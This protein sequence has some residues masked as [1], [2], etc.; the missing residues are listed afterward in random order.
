MKKT[1]SLVCFF[2]LC[3][4]IHSQAQVVEWIHSYET[5]TSSAHAIASDNQANLYFA[6]YIRANGN[7][8][9]GLTLTYS[10]GYE[11]GLVCKADSQGHLQWIKVLGAYSSEKAKY[12]FQKD[13]KVFVG[14]DVTNYGGNSSLQIDNLS[15][16]IP[17]GPI[18]SGYVVQLDTAGIFQWVAFLPGM[19]SS[20]KTDDSGNTYATCNFNDAFIYKISPTGTVVYGFPYSTSSYNCAIAFDPHGNAYGAVNFTDTIEFMGTTYQGH[21]LSDILLFKVSSSGSLLHSGIIGGIGV[22]YV[23]GMMTDHSGNI[24]MTGAWSDTV[25]FSG[26][27]INGIGSRYFILKADTADNLIDYND[28]DFLYPDNNASSWAGSIVEN[29][30]HEI[31]TAINFTDTII[32]GADTLSSHNFGGYDGAGMIAKWDSTLQL[33]WYRRLAQSTNIYNTG[34]ASV[35]LSKAVADKIY[36]CGQMNEHTII[37]GNNYDTNGYYVAFTGLLRDTTFDFTSHLPDDEIQNLGFNIYPSPAS[38]KVYFS[39]RSTEDIKTAQIE[40]HNLYGELIFYKKLSEANGEIDISNLP[41][42][43]YYF[44]FIADNFT[45]TKSVVKIE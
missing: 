28:Q 20:M 37:E 26:T 19:I 38:G 10:Y 18:Y 42:G 32:H 39:L 16:P 17:P 31:L 15:F 25:Y 35:F 1:F 30:N 40:L 45:Q 9:D 8:F 2:C 4:F 14:G 13:D 33:Q 44:K 3:G 29:D 43:V 24:V 27:T 22:D 12:I 21:G 34:H 23:N 36:I 5:V 41:I 6:G 11:D 7:P